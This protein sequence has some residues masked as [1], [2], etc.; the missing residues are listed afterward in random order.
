MTTIRIVSNYTEIAV[1]EAGREGHTLREAKSIAVEE[2]RRF[3][4]VVVVEVDGTN[5]FMAR[6]GALYRLTRV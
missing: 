2:S 6:H 1:V 4:D 5:R 3:D